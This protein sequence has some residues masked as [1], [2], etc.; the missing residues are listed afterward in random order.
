[1]ELARVLVIN[2][3]TSWLLTFVFLSTAGTPFINIYIL[4]FAEQK[5]K[6]MVSS[7]YCRMLIST[8]FLPTR[9]PLYLFTFNAFLIRP[10]KPSATILNKRGANGSPCLSPFCGVNSAV[11]LPLIRIDIEAHL[12]KHENQK[13]PTNRVICLLI[14]NFE[15]QTA[16]SISLHFLHRFIGY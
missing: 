9:S 5:K 12:P 2:I 14:V 6:K 15:Y 7:A 11:G 13:V 8:P 3:G 1:M 16:L 10:V 4:I